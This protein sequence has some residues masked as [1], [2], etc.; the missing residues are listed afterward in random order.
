VE[1]SLGLVKTKT[2]KITDSQGL[3]FCN[4][5]RTFYHLA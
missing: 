4:I 5:I 3:R 1:R 2:P